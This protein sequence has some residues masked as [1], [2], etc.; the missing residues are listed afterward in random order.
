MT[1][2]VSSETLSFNLHIHTLTHNTNSIVFKG[3]PPM[4]SDAQLAEISQGDLFLLYYQGW[5][6]WVLSSKNCQRIYGLFEISF[7]FC[8]STVRE[9]MVT[10]CMLCKH[11]AFWRVELGPNC[12]K[13]H[14]ALA[15]SLWKWTLAIPAF[16]TRLHICISLLESIL[17]GR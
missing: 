15:Y 7:Y 3:K 14:G 11:S 1:Y 10:R 12:C 17:R 16:I 8:I 13:Q 6:V 9:D 4:G 5:S 2:K